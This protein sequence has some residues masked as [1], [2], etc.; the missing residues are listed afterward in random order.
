MTTVSS[1]THQS[2]RLETVIYQY[3]QGWQK[4]GFV[5]AITRILRECPHDIVAFTRRD[6]ARNYARI[7]STLYCVKCIT[8]SGKSKLSGMQYHFH[9]DP[10]DRLG[11]HLLCASASSRKF[12]VLLEPVKPEVL[13]KLEDLNHSLWSSTGKRG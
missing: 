7:G 3:A 8:V 6:S 5:N 9:L 13:A 11:C 12:C 1:G 4:K 10:A 2:P